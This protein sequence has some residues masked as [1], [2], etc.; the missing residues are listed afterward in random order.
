MIKATFIS[1]DLCEKLKGKLRKG[2]KEKIVKNA[3]LPT[4]FYDESYFGEK[5]S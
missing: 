1:L 5:G 3:Y 4:E 2:Q